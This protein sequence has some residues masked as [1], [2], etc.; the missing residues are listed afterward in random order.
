MRRLQNSWN[1]W[2][3]SSAEDIRNLLSA[4]HIARKQRKAILWGCGHII[5][6]VLGL[7]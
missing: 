4:I 6:S 1:H 5:K 7:F 2:P 3:N